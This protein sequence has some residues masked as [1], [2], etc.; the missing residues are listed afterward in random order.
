MASSGS[1][2]KYFNYNGWTR[3][4]GHAYPLA[5]R[6]TPVEDHTYGSI[7][8]LTFAWQTESQDIS[9]GETTIS[10]SLRAFVP[11]TLTNITEPVGLMGIAADRIF[12]NGVKLTLGTDHLSDLRPSV[13]EDVYIQFGNNELDLDYSTATYKA[14]LTPGSTVELKTGTYTIEHLDTG[15]A[16]GLAVECGVYVK[17][18]WDASGNPYFLGDVWPTGSA[19]NEDMGARATITTSIIVDDLPYYAQI[20]SAP[21]F[22]D[23]DSPVIS[24]VIPRG[25]TEAQVCISFTGGNDDISYRTIDLQ[26]TSYTFEF[27]TADKLALWSLLDQG[28]TSTTM[29]FYIK[30][31]FVL[32]DAAGGASSGTQWHYVTRTV[33]LVNYEPVL[34]PTVVDANE[35]TLALTGNANILIRYA[36]TASFNSYAVARKGANIST[37]YVK[38][39]E[40]FNYDTAGEI[41]GPTSNTFYFSAT[42]NRGHTT[43]DAVVF[44]ID[45]GNFIEYVKPT[46]SAIVGDMT[47][48]GEVEVTINGKYFSGNF[49]AT[50]N[51]L[52]VGYTLSENNG[53]P[54][55][56][57]IGAVEPTMSGNDYTYTFT[58]TGL[59]YTSVYEVSINVADK[60][61]TEGTITNV[62]LAST[63][64][65]DWSN[66]DFNFN[67]PV[68][69]GDGFT[70]PQR[71][72]WRGELQL[73]ADDVIELE[74]DDVISKQPTGIVLVFSLYRDGA[75]ENASLHSFFVS[76][77]EVTTL[78][79]YSPHMFMMGINSN[80]SVFGSKYVYIG[81]ARIS[82]FSGNTASGTAACGITFDN[83][84]FVLRYIL[85]V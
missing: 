47:A 46:V 35:K 32:N 73:G 5:E 24:Y 7:L 1:I 20:T 6:T 36:S 60:I 14:D 37:Q 72:I 18:V 33:S 2:T 49:G 40:V 11:S 9:K 81:N 69:L 79:T 65:F 63:P 74:G 55:Q 29:R 28:I 52:T 56:H 78:F 26:S 31:N 85:G 62:V 77:T 13:Q 82:G 25:V 54:T 16:S 38:N 59:D 71:M 15:K 75:A 66:K 42:D 10:W 22:T 61:L 48:T 8:G 21:D 12:G 67:V 17:N 53:E 23:E 76:K 83:S 27:T 64:V 58:I 43:K 68:N 70:Y 39:G 51:T 57:T 44:S 34:S 41:E 30:S 19:Y 50:H 84:K 4:T 45:D 3:S 80:L